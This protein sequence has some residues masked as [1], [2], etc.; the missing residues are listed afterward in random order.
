MMIL[1][2]LAYVLAFAAPTTIAAVL[3]PAYAPW[4]VG[5]AV[6]TFLMVS[7]FILGWQWD[8]P[9]WTPETR[10]HLRQILLIFVWLPAAHAIWDTI[11]RPEKVALYAAALVGTELGLAIT[12]V[13]PFYLG[14]AMRRR[15]LALG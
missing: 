13:P 3:L 6:I 8:D 10:G 14:R 4:I 7:G 2:L 15:R 1:Q 9:G 5:G 11:R 12:T